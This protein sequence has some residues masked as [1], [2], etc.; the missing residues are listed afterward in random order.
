V[1]GPPPPPLTQCTG[2]YCGYSRGE[3]NP[4]VVLRHTARSSKGKSSCCC[5]KS[6]M[7]CYLHRNVGCISML[8]Y[9]LASATRT[10][11]ILCYILRSCAQSS[12]III[13][14]FKTQNA[15][16]LAFKFPYF[17]TREW[18][19]RPKQVAYIDENKSSCGRRQYVCQY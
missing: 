11:I 5:P 15:F 17:K 8:A 4:T 6:A 2:V 12:D 19:T 1:S 18:C 10:F 14:Y 9:V 3:K 7:K 16:I 13:R